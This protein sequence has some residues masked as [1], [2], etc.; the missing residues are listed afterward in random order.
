MTIL[1]FKANTPVSGQG[2]TPTYMHVHTYMYTHMYTHTNRDRLM[3]KEAN[4]DDEH[5]WPKMH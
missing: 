1:G 5:S 3:E 4:T 2:T